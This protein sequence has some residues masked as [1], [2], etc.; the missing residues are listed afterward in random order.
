MFSKILKVK[1]LVWK[2]LWNVQFLIRGDQGDS[3]K[4][5]LQK[6]RFF[7]Q[8]FLAKIWI[9]K[10]YKKSR[11]LVRKYLKKIEE[12]WS[13][14]PVNSMFCGQKSFLGIHDS[15]GHFFLSRGH[16]MNFSKRFTIFGH[17]LQKSWILSKK[18]L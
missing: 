10:K 11:Y 7:S 17:F 9:L 6:S 5:I 13:W 2:F 14:T 3:L 18:F 12:F 4:T 16:W 15:K 8:E 1:D